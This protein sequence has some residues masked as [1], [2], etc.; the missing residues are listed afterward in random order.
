LQ[1]NGNRYRDLQDSFNQAAWS[2]S[3]ATES[4]LATSIQRIHCVASQRFTTHLMYALSSSNPEFVQM[5][6][7]KPDMGRP[8]ITSC[9]HE[10]SKYGLARC[11][12]I[13]I[14][15][16]SWR[17]QIAAH[18]EF[19]STARGSLLQMSRFRAKKGTKTKF[20]KSRDQTISYR[21]LPIHAKSDS[22]FR[23]S[24]VQIEI[25]NLS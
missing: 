5:A 8:I 25:C 21:G 17:A 18:P 15:S 9:Q 14:L 7:G 4:G 3:S 19:W 20:H 10:R 22:S 24:V 12:R 6:S 16:S 1:A 11:I 2:Y 13:Q 23:P